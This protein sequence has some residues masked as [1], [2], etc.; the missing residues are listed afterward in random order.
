MSWLSSSECS[1]PIV[2]F[3]EVA[4]NNNSEVPKRAETEVAKSIYIV[5]VVAAAV[6]F[7]TVSIEVEQNRCSDCM[8][9]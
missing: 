2:C 1:F 6:S 7:V 5:V 3:G 8:R 9:E 4:K